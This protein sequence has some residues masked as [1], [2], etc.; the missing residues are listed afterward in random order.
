MISYCLETSQEN[1]LSKNTCIRV[2]KCIPRMNYYCESGKG[3]ESGVLTSII[4]S[5]KQ[6]LNESDKRSIISELNN[7]E[8]A[9][10]KESNDNDVVKRYN[11]CLVEVRS[12]LNIL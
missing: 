5:A 8:G 11:T 4:N 2:S 1:K 10:F 12:I 7:F 6:Y 9:S 3:Y